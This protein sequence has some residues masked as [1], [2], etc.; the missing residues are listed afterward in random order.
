MPEIL[1][2]PQQLY[3]TADRV[4]QGARRIQVA[5]D[6][7]DRTIYQLNAAGF[8]GIRSELL[9]ARYRRTKSQIDSYKTILE[10]FANDLRS[11]AAAFEKADR[12]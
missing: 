1:V 9:I 12:R 5:M 6:E 4:A 11:T 8:E 10:R 7:V 2:N 3:A